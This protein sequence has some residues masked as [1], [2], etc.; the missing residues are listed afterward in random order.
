MFAA[1]YMEGFPSGQ[2][3]QTVNLLSTTSMV[4][5]HLPPPKIRVLPLGKGRIFYGVLAGRRSY[6]AFSEGILLCRIRKKLV[7]GGLS[8]ESVQII[9]KII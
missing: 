9:A 8:E 1:K 2:R 3:G 6:F 7:A 4:R 5:I